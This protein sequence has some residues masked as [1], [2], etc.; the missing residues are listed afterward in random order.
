MIPK[1]EDCKPGITPV[2]YRVL[3]ALDVLEEVT[4]G[5]IILPG[6]MLDRENSASEKGRVIEVSPMAFKGGDWEGC[7]TPKAGD[8]V[9][10]QR[11]AGSE[12][13]GE[14][15]KKYRIINDEDLKGI[16]NG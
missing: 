4:V 3:V 10:F 7:P 8:V 13:E 12:V 1:I 14:D 15:G 2:G 16:C 6:K 5:G 9:M 11:Y